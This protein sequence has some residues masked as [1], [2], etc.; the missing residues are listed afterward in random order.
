MIGTQSSLFLHFVFNPFYTM[1]LGQLARQFDITPQEIISYLK[2][3]GVDLNPHPNSKLDDES[4]R[5][6]MEHFDV[7]PMIE[8]VSVIEEA[9]ENTAVKEETVKEEAAVITDSSESIIPKKTKEKSTPKKIKKKVKENIDD[10]DWDAEDSTV[11]TEKQSKKEVLN[12]EPESSE[13][14]NIEKSEEIEITQTEAEIVELEADPDPVFVATV[15][16]LLADETETLAKKIALIKA[17]KVELQGLKVLGKIELPQPK[18]KEAPTEEH[19]EAEKPLKTEK[20]SAGKG[21]F[22]NRKPLS[23]EEREK[24]RAALQEKNREKQEWEAHKQKIRKSRQKKAAREEYYKKQVLEVAQVPT[25][26]ATPIKK[27]VKKKATPKAPKKPV[28]KTILGKVWRWL[29]T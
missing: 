14:E 25:A 4:E 13:V 7:L 24:K 15:D 12:K 20:P 28:P 23:P 29:N 10:I 8:E 11:V 16:E 5:L 6:V 2:A 18:E 1:R 21:K 9:V 27:K 19:E 17:K 22:A 3:K 26:P